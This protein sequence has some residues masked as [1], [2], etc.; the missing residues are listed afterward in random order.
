MGMGIDSHGVIGIEVRTGRAVTVTPDHVPYG[1]RGRDG[2]PVY[3]HMVSQFLPLAKTGLAN[4]AL[5]GFD[6]RVDSSHVLQ[7][8]RCVH[9]HPVT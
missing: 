9:K 6:P 2:N 8:V 5:L 7:P 1:F 3:L 4:R